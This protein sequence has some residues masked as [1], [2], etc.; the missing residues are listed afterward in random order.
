MAKYKILVVPSD[1]T[2]VGHF[3]SI[4]PH[5]QLEK[6]YPDLFSIDIDY[7]P[8][9]WNPNVVKKYSL[10]HYHRNLGDYDKM[11][12]LLNFIEM[13]G[14]KTMLDIDD[15]WAPGDHHPAHLLIKQH[16]LDELI[17]NSVKISKMVSTTTP[18]FA[19]EIKKLNKNVVVIPNAINPEE[20]QF[21]PKDMGDNS[22]DRIRIGWLGGSSHKVDLNLLSTSFKRL[23]TENITDNIKFYLCGF[24]TRG[25]V[26]II[27]RETNEQTQRPIKPKESVWYEYERLFTND[28]SAL[29][30]KYKE[31][32]MK[33]D[34]NSSYDST[35]EGYRRVWTKPIST[36]ATNY[37]FF[38]ISLSPLK[39]NLFNRVKSQLKVVEAGFYKKALIAQNFGPYKI[40]CI[41]AWDRGKWND[42]GNSL[43]VESTRNHNE[44]YDHIK[45]LVKNPS[46]I[47]ELGERLY[48]TVKDKYS[49]NA[50][51][52]LRKEIYLNLLENKNVI[53]VEKKYHIIS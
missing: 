13:L 28:Y 35:G 49:I 38:D 5:M 14:V 41:N 11:E 50:T 4:A 51:C 46:M 45:R 16:K 37:N 53:E 18:A 19:D 42:K 17:A 39:E 31:W 8:D 25:A 34:K 33:F 15:Y 26:T 40:D 29:S 2:G 12:N 21:Q 27:N 36:Y 10:I 6:L 30:P 9:L 43:L 7:T 1:R 20:E 22:N 24:D 52:E 32:L 3:R 23:Y 48:D 47:T 44:W